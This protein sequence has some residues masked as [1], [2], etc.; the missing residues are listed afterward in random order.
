MLLCWFKIAYTSAYGQ[1]EEKEEDGENGE[2]GECA[3]AVKPRDCFC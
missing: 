2:N 1:E 3:H